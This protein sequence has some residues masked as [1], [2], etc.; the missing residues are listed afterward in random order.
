MSSADP[1]LWGRVADDL[2]MDE[3]DR[4]LQLA[5]AAEI[6]EGCN[7]VQ[8]NLIEDPSKF[9]SGLCPRRAGKSYCATAYALYLGEKFP[10]SRVLIIGLTLKAAKENYWSHAPG[11]IQA[12]DLKYELGLEPNYAEVSWTHTNGSVGFL[13][14]AETAADLERLRGSKVE[15]DLVVID[16]AKS[17]APERLR[18]LIMDV[19][20]PGLMTRNGT[21]CMIG[22]PGSIPLGPFFEATSE[23]SVDALGLPTC[24][25]WARRTEAKYKALTTE[26]EDG[27]VVPRWSTHHWTL[28]DNLA[29]KHQWDRAKINK[30]MQGWDD[31]HP[32]W[33]REYLGEWVEDASELVYA[34]AGIRPTGRVTWHPDR[35]EH[36]HGLDPQ[37]GPWHMLLGVD[38][39][40]EDDFALVVA[41]YGEHSKE[42]RHIWDWKSP[43][44]TVD[45]M[46][47]KIKEA[48]RAYGPFESIIVDAGALGKTILETFL[49]HGIAA[50]PA[51]KH[52][53]YDYIELLNSDFRAGR[54]KIL[55]DSELHHELCALQWDLSMHSKE[56]LIRTGKLRESPDCANHLCDALLYLWRYSYHSLSEPREAPPPPK[57]SPEWWAQKVERE[58]REAERAS[59]SEASSISG[60]RFGVVDHFVTRSRWN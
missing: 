54:L 16:E 15:V 58:K 33:R 52:E 25:P 57:Y 51:D 20:L 9:K 1:F 5:R 2:G 32:V 43:H 13:A 11:G 55:P 31:K 40:Y 59:Q 8:R 27:D 38:L 18:E 29:K 36:P 12:L 44:M 24:I 50:I 56:R 10:G 4:E 39:G 34:Y 17:F 37:E 42:L 47:R 23:N 60:R 3:A 21:I 28:A 41:A 6:L 26:D 46:E 30:K 14:G 35:S 48:E 45:D 49:S 53:K 7:P 22:T 19:L